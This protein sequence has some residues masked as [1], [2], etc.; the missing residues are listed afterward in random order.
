MM[1]IN[2]QQKSAYNYDF[3]QCQG[4]FSEVDLLVLNGQQEGLQGEK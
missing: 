3:N 1:K 4:A 2:M